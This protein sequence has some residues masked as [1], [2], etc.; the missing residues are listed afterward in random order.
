[1]L[2]SLEPGRV[3]LDPRNAEYKIASGV[4]ENWF[5]GFEPRLARKEKAIPN[6]YHF[7]IHENNNLHFCSKPWKKRAESHRDYVL[8]DVQYFGIC[9]L[10]PNMV[11][12]P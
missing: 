9:Q 5:L 11:I 10:A 1:M 3:K 7:A 12:P 4:W 6:L 2:G 8:E